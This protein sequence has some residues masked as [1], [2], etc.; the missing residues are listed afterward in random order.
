[1]NNSIFIIS[2]SFFIVI[3]F[4]FFFMRMDILSAFGH[5]LNTSFFQKSWI[6]SVL[7]GFTLLRPR[8]LI[9]TLFCTLCF[10]AILIV[11]MFCFIHAFFEI[12]L[13]HAFIGT[14]AMMFV[15]SCLPISLGDLGIREAG[16][17]FFFS[18]FGVSQ[19]SAL[20]ASLLLFVVNILVP[21]IFGTIFLKYQ[22]LTAW[23]M[24]KS[25]VSKT[26]THPHD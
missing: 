17:I 14:N 23:T 6:T 19:A 9:A 3:F 26:K 11:Q 7:D 13:F 12:T 1:L 8:Q 24:V 4:L 15:K 16:S 2:L 10:Q 20:N 5:R 22:H 21:S 18:K 25:L